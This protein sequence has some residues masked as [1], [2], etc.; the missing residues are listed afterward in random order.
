[1]EIAV[2]G[3][4]AGLGYVASQVA[5]TRGEVP[6]VPENVE[7]QYADNPSAPDILPRVL[8]YYNMPDTDER[9]PHNYP[10]PPRDKPDLEDQGAGTSLAQAFDSN[11]GYRDTGPNDWGAGDVT[12]TLFPQ[13]LFP[14]FGR[15]AQTPLY[16]EALEPEYFKPPK[17]TVL[18]DD[19]RQEPMPQPDVYGA[20]SI[21]GLSRDYVD[22]YTKFRSGSGALNDLYPGAIPGGDAD[23][24][25]GPERYAGYGFGNGE[26]FTLRTGGFHPRLRP[27]RMPESQQKQ[28]YFSLRNP[29]FAVGR[30]GSI[31]AEGRGELGNYETPFNAYVKE[32]HR[33]AMPTAGLT[34]DRMRANPAVVLRCN[35]RQDQYIG[36]A[37]PKGTDDRAQENLRLL[38]TA[39]IGASRTC[40]PTY[41]KEVHPQLTFGFRD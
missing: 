29:S 14:L 39:E 35:S 12:N 36:W 7:E 24:G 8:P 34:S 32:Y 40:V 41:G 17:S 26:K 1:M 11:R 21:V 4:I 2:L 27:F 25:P 13:G 16:I 23:A 5:S 9:N 6:S 31:Y 10:G 22:P 3:A 33:E 15:T 19:L 28:L 20:K 18:Q 30:S 38:T 37:G